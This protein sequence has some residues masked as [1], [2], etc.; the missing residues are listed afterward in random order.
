MGGVGLYHYKVWVV[1]SV[2]DRYEE[3][4]G[5]GGKPSSKL[6]VKPSETG[7]RLPK[8]AY[9]ENTVIYLVDVDNLISKLDKPLDDIIRGRYF[10]RDIRT[11]MED[12]KINSRKEARRLIIRA[13][14]T[15]FHELEK[16]RMKPRITRT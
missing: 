4:R 14:N 16:H 9:F 5:I 10:E 11:F 13:V 1:G 12:F 6:F 3:L 8:G 15:F 2:L 7:E